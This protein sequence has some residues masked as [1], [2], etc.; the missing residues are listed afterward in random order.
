MLELVILQIVT[1]L[2]YRLYLY[3]PVP[4]SFVFLALRPRFPIALVGGGSR[5]SRQNN[6]KNVPMMIC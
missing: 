3:L 2:R 4:R 6:L 1:R 5:H